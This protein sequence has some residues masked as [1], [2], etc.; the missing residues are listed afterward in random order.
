MAI[1]FGSEEWLKAFTQE[2]S[3]SQAYKEAAKKWDGDLYFIIEP[4]ASLKDKIVV[5][6]DLWHGECRSSALV[7]DESEKT[8]AYR[9]WGLFSVW[10]Q[11]LEKKLDPVQAMMTGRLKVKGDMAQIMRMPRAAVELVNCVTKF[12]TEFPD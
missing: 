9:I 1:K 12:E 2:I 7:A 11:I 6:V 5:Y 10:R 4:E 3:Q 8:P